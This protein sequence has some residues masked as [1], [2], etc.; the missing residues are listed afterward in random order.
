MT[1]RTKPKHWWPSPA[2][3]NLFLHIN[4]QN[5]KGYH[6]LQTLFQLVDIGDQLAFEVTN[7][8]IITLET[9]LEGV[10]QQDNLIFKAAKQL[11]QR[12]GSTLGCN[13]WLDK[14][15]PMGGG[16]GGGS[17]NAATTLVALNALWKTHLSFS[18]LADLG[19]ALGADVPIFVHGKTAFA[20][21]VGEKITPT[22]LSSPYYLIVF[23]NC[24]V[25]TAEIFAADDLVRNSAKIEW[26]DYKF[27]KTRND[28]QKLVCDRYPKVANLLRQL[29]EYAPSRMTGT[30]ACLF[31]VFDTIEQAEQVKRILPE[32]CQAFVAKG[33]NT[34]PL[35]EYLAKMQLTSA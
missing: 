11:Q 16:I 13:I 10:A 19:L 29:L 24:H 18:E 26:Q 23:P 7:D 15:L 8:G 3:L 32:D 14:Q 27:A 22:E 28:C 25:S 12:S 4:G 9:A 1:Q 31:S 2:K 17:S 35:H 21:G 20:E 33:I 34:S 30:G 5:E 6:L